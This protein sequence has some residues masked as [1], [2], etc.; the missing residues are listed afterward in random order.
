MIPTYMTSSSSSPF[1]FD[2]NYTTA[3]QYDDD[4]NPNLFFT[5]S[6]NYQAAASSSSN[7]NHPSSSH[8][9]LNYDP[10]FYQPPAPNANDN[11]GSY[12]NMEA[13]KGQAE[14]GHNKWRKEEEK[15][16]NEGEKSPEKV[17][18]MPAKM[19]LVKKVRSS[20]DRANMEVVK[21]NVSA[22][23]IED[24]HQKGPSL[25]SSL[26]TDHS[27][28]SSSSNNGGN[29]NNNNN[30][31]VLIVRVCADCNTTKTPL[32]RSGPKGPK[33]LCNACG[34]RQRKARRA[35]AAANGGANGTAP[36]SPSTLK[37]KVQKTTVAK[38]NNNYPSHHQQPLKKRCKFVTAAEASA[39]PS[40]SDAAKN[41]VEDFLKKLSNSLA[42]HR[43]FPQDEKDAAILL[44]AISCGLVHG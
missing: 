14:S 38:S 39:A 32:W 33:S 23:K 12:D 21:I 31:N 43:V 18:M 25:S 13:K 19:K 7:N 42:L 40:S 10:Q 17:M 22:T 5:S 15:Y 41:G 29:G 3:D 11:W 9:F 4:Q 26:E 35:M 24:H 27:S 44:M 30:N 28:H 37:L 34:I 8:L 16:E 1:P 2:L 36:S 6:S 20:S